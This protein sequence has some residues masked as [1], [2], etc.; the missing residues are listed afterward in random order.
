M[1]DKPEQKRILTGSSFRYTRV[2]RPP[3][4][5]FTERNYE[6]EGVPYA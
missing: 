3:N 6:S 2:Q 5:T 4:G 1:T